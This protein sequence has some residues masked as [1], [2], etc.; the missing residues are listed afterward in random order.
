MVTALSGIKCSS[1]ITASSCTLIGERDSEWLTDIQAGDHCAH[2]LK[3]MVLFK[4]YMIKLTTAGE[5]GI[6]LLTIW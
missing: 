6:E 5:S 4:H 2:N 3:F 1:R